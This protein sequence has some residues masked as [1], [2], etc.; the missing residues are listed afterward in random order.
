[1][2]YVWLAFAAGLTITLVM[3]YKMQ[4]SCYPIV[5]LMYAIA[6]FITGGIIRFTPLIICGALSFPISVFAFFVTFENQIILLALSVLVS[7]I[8]PGHWMQIKFKQQS[9]HGTK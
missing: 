1:M 8:I 2:M 3:G 4:L 7:Y 5:I 9:A 6:T